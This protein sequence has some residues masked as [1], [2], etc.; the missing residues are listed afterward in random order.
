MRAR[1]GRYDLLLAG[2]VGLGAAA[3]RALALSDP[4]HAETLRPHH[5]QRRPEHHHACFPRAPHELRRP[6]PQADH[7]FA[8]DPPARLRAR[9]GADRRRVDAGHR[10][11]HR[12]RPHVRRQTPGVHLAVRHA[13]PVDAG[14]GA[15]PLQAG[16]RDR[17]D[18]VRAVSCGRCAA[19][20]TRRRPQRWRARHTAVR[21]SVCRFT[22]WRADR[23]RR[24][25]CVAGR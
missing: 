10:V 15:K 7:D 8:R 25:R 12:H 3:L 4:T 11:P 20:R 5:A 21:R 17:G 13:R 19:R 9:G 1:C 24:G 2:A 22:E 6:A 18:R 23:E 16:G 14:G